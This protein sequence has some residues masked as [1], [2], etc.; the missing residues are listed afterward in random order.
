MLRWQ[1][2]DRHRSVSAHAAPSETTRRLRLPEAA[3]AVDKPNTAATAARRET[4]EVRAR[5]SKSNL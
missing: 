1:E 5:A 4:R 2:P 3:S